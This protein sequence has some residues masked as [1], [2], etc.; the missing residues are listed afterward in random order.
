MTDYY[1]TKLDLEGVPVDLL[2]TETEVKKTAARALKNP[3]MVPL[4]NNSCWPI[5][6]PKKKCGLLKWI[7]GKCCDCTTCDC[8]KNG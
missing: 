5:D 8:E 7:M 3:D 1:H 4:T 2:L 6:T